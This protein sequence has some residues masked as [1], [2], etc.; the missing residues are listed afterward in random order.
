MT[1]EENGRKNAQNDKSLIN[2]IY[3]KPDFPSTKK[4]LRKL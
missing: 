4:I 1:L 3:M 2:T